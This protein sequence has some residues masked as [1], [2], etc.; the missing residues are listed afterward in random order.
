MKRIKSSQTLRLFIAEWR[1][2]R[3]LSQEDLANRIGTTK[4]SVSR[5]ET[6]K[7]D[8][9]GE[10]IASISTALGVEP[11]QLFRHPT[12]TPLDDILGAASPTL[13]RKAEK[14]LKALIED[15]TGLIDLNIGS[16]KAKH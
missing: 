5:W 6:G 14:V 3:G 8:I 13:R 9:T 10:V 4:A 2:V 16:I 7:R 12:D 1:E 11:V 15:E